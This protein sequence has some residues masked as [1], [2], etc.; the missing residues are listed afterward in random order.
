MPIKFRC[1]YCRQLM[2]IAHNKAG[3]MIDCPTCGRRLRVPNQDG[4]VDPPPA[5]KVDHADDGLRRA[6]DELALIGIPDDEP[7]TKPQ[8]AG[9]VLPE[10]SE[11]IAKSPLTL[12]IGN[13]EA[14]PLAP[15]TARAGEPAAAT[16]VTPPVKPSVQLVNSLAL[17][18]LPQQ[19]VMNPPPLPR[20]SIAGASP[21]VQPVSLAGSSPEE[22]LAELANQA[23]PQR[24][25]AIVAP[26]PVVVRGYSLSLVLLVAVLSFVAGI[27]AGWGL[28]R[29]YVVQRIANVNADPAAP[30]QPETPATKPLVR[31]RI[32]YRNA[33]GQLEPDA[34]ATVLI[35]PLQPEKTIKKIPALGLRPSDDPADHERASKSLSEQGG[36]LA[37]VNDEGNFQL[38]L[39]AAGA[40]RLLVLSHFQ[41]Q[42]Q[43]T[44]TDAATRQTVEELEAQFE[45]PEQLLGKLAFELAEIKHKGTG[46]VIWDHTFSPN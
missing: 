2:G 8:S 19:V 21:P 28:G 43:D 30:T 26:C 39:P 40:Y 33:Q 27:A 10:P 46:T 34:G 24:P 29:V 15:P 4:T 42:P 6:L 31:G 35:L 1:N 25:A 41:G 22:I 37:I 16:V 13:P 17:E 5:L 11:L 14:S 7:E 36:R 38:E 23:A 3:S 9:T 18:P 12:P 20:S 44:D 32:T 45:R